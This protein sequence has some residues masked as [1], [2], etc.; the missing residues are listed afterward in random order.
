LASCEDLDYKV[1]VELYNA[2][3]AEKGEQRFEK[4]KIL[5]KDYTGKKNNLE[6]IFE[7][8]YVNYVVGELDK[9]GVTAITLESNGYPKLLENCEDAPLVLFCKGNTELLNGNT[10]S[11]VGSRKSLPLSIHLAEEFSLALIEK[12]FTLVTGIA[13]GVD[14]TVLKTALKNNG[15]VI[16]VICGG[17]NNIYPKSHQNI[18]N[19]VAK[20]GLVISESFLT[21]IPKP[22]MFPVRNRIIAGL[23]KGTLIVNGSKKSGTIHTANYC[24]DYG[25]E[26]FAI[27]Y[28]V[29]VSSGEG[30][31]YLISLGATLTQKPEDIFNYF[32]IDSE[33]KKEQILTDEEKKIISALTNGI[34]HVEEISYKTGIEFN[35]V[36]SLLSLMEIK[37]PISYPLFINS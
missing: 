14:V 23:S 10:F 19:E 20:C 16:S 25:R 28:S 22:F 31:N 3:K 26:V 6:K 27:P 8:S 36:C 13:E 2:V 21:V 7:E 15:K 1:K 17:F 12:G 9:N 30:N 34:N 32:G 11:I 4:A 37:N 35:K 33:R 18:F 5:I 29:N 24:L